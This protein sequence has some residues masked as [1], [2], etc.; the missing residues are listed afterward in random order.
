MPSLTSTSSSIAGCSLYRK[1]GKHESKHGDYFQV[2][3]KSAPFLAPSVGCKVGHSYDA[4]FREGNK[5]H[6]KQ[7]AWLDPALSVDKTRKVVNIIA[8]IAI[9]AAIYGFIRCTEAHKAKRQHIRVRFASILGPVL[10]TISP[11]RTSQFMLEMYI[12]SIVDPHRSYIICYDPFLVICLLRQFSR[13]SFSLK[14]S[15]LTVWQPLFR[16]DHSRK[17]IK[18]YMFRLSPFAASHSCLI[19]QLRRTAL[20][21]L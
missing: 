9:N 1:K 21:Q 19:T 4:V 10:Q 8:R 16:M 17:I 2:G 20:H 18:F 11:D 7:M 6:Q 3:K 13:S 12:G 15:S 5:D 14:E